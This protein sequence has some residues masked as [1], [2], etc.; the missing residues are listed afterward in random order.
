MV[1]AVAAAVAIELG[2]Q[3]AQTGRRADSM[4]VQPSSVLFSVRTVTWFAPKLGQ[5]PKVLKKS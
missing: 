4:Q 3:V 1:A 2:E 5:P